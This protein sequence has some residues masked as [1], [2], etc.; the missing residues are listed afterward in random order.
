MLLIYVA[1]LRQFRTGVRAGKIG[2][3]ARG[4]VQE[5]IQRER[6][7]LQ[8]LAG[9]FRFDCRQ[10]RASDDIHLIPEVLTDEHGGV[11]GKQMRQR[12]ALSLSGLTPLRARPD[13]TIDGGEEQRRA[14]RKQTTGIGHVAIN[15]G[16]QI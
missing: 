3:K 8:H 10:G 15:E 5:R 1:A 12:G 4:I 16:Y 11:E 2:K 9:Q 13:G 6:K 14:D 7:L